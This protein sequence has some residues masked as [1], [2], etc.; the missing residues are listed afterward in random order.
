M[1]QIFALVGWARA[2]ARVRVIK[3]T[4][5]QCAHWLQWK[6]LILRFRCNSQSAGGNFESAASDSNREI[7]IREVILIQLQS[8]D[9]CCSK[10]VIIKD[11]RK[12]TTHT[13]LARTPHTVNQLQR[14]R[15]LNGALFWWEFRSTKIKCHWK[16]FE[17]LVKRTM[18][19]SRPPCTVRIEWRALN[20]TKM[21]VKK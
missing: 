17:S 9:W 8:P 3:L 7:N 5:R 16:R 19:S 13:M 20:M 6:W 4:H 2:R 10:I 21:K 11:R 18:A 14:K 15:A 1:G 12:N